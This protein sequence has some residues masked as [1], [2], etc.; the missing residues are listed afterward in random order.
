M[1]SKDFKVSFSLDESDV[2]YFRNLYRTAKKHASLDER[3]SIIRAARKLIETVRSSTKTPSFVEEAVH[4]LEDLIEMLEDAD[5]ALPK[6]VSAEAVAALAYFANPGDVI[7]D[8]I[9]ALGFLDDAIMIKLVEDE[10]KHELWAFR[11]FRNF[12]A[13]AEQRPWTSVAR[14]RLP[15]RLAEYRRQLRA[16][17][18]E[19]KAADSTRR[20]SVW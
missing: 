7:P 3:D 9:P 8:H 1:A 10:F 15:K 13:G 12:R 16:K 20:R 5:Y 17:V 18:A 14:E 11:K 4:A 19:K 6:H 2:A